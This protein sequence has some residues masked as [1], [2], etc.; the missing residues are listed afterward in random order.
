ML[1]V[2]QTTILVPTDGIATYELDDDLV[3]YDPVTGKGQLLNQSAAHIWALCDGRRGMSS[4]AQVLADDYG[5]DYARA[6]HD[7][8]ELLEDLQDLGFLISLSTGTGAVEQAARLKLPYR[9]SRLKRDG[10]SGGT[11]APDFRLPDL[12]GVN[13]SLAELRGAPVLLVFSDPAC[14]PCQILTPDLARLSQERAGELS[15]LMISRGDVEA[16]RAK[17]LEHDIRF[18][19]LLQKSWEISKAYAIFA[20]PVAYLIDGTGIISH[21]VAV[22]RQG[23]LELIEHH[24]SLS[25]AQDG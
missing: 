1:T 25:F 23:I 9:E 22:G 20:T 17:V 21:D 4:V 12:N 7:V 3:L 6:L 18:P 11:V 14:G 10:L 16:N 8:Q 19:V 13:H 2:N 24:H 15:I 5:I